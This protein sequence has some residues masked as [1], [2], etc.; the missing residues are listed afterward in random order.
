MVGSAFK[1]GNV[2]IFENMGF[3][4]HAIYPSAVHQYLSP[5]DNRYHGVAKQRWRASDVDF[6]NDVE[7]S[8]RLL[9]E[10][11]NIKP[12]HVQKWFTKN[13]QL[14]RDEASIEAAEK[15]IF[16]FERNENDRMDF[17]KQCRQEYE[18]EIVQ[19]QKR[20]HGHIVHKPSSLD[21][22]FD[23]DYWTKFK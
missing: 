8:L 13:L 17:F 19:K 11:D 22:A 15:V 20:G 12:K 21:S 14:Y 9:Y 7:S 2:D 16:G 23:G 5:N 3:A 10:L 4:N 6:S 18:E 1:V